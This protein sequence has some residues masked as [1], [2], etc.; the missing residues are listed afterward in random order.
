[1]KIRRGYVSNSSTTSFV[2]CGFEINEPEYNKEETYLDE[3]IEEISEKHKCD[4]INKDSII[5]LGK[6]L[7]KWDSENNDETYKEVD[8]ETIKAEV[9]RIRRE[10]GSDNLIRL[11]S[12]TYYR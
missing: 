8:L 3:V 6:I 11:Y 9:E 10:Y 4:Y 2:I 7:A 1:M 12:G 5:I